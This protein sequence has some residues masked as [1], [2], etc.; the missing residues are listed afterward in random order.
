MYILYSI[1]AICRTSCI[2][3]KYMNTVDLG[4]IRA[5]GTLFFIFLFHKKK[6]T[7]KKKHR[8]DLHD[9]RLVIQ[10]HSIL[11]PHPPPPPW[12]RSIKIYPLRIKDQKCRHVHPHQKLPKFSFP[13][14]KKAIFFQTPRKYLKDQRRRRSDPSEMTF[15]DPSENLFHQGDVDIKWNG[16][17]T[18]VI[19]KI[20]LV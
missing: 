7:N 13:L 15:K 6:Q 2:R 18:P 20:V 5:L 14:R 12:K 16:P 3:L 17:Q 4:L 10:G 19:S 1:L 9:R 11:Y 8:H